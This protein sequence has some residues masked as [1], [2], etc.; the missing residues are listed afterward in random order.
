M[1]EDDFSTRRIGAAE[2]SKLQDI[3]AKVEA[4]PSVPITITVDLYRRVAAVMPLCEL[5]AGSEEAR[6]IQAVHEIFEA[7]LRDYEV[8]NDLG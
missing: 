6:F 8:R 7:G 3:L 5:D 2:M 4:V 1:S